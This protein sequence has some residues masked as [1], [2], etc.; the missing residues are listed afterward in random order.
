MFVVVVVVILDV[1]SIRKYISYKIHMGPR[2]G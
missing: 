1:K 2:F